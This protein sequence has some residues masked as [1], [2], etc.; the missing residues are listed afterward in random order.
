MQNQTTWMS[1]DC[2]RMPA[3][4]IMVGTWSVPQ[5]WHTAPQCVVVLVVL[6]GADLGVCDSGV[7]LSCNSSLLSVYRFSWTSLARRGKLE[8]AAVCVFV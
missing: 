5:L 7:F 1:L 2:Q 6:V 4:E 3:S 8:I